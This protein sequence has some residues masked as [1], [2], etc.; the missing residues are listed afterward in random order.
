MICVLIIFARLQAVTD[1]HS[2]PQPYARG[3]FL[4]AG[5]AVYLQAFAVVIF[6]KSGSGACY[7]IG[8]VIDWL[9]TTMLYLC[10]GIIIVSI[11]TLKSCEYSQGN[12]QFEYWCA[13]EKKD[14]TK[15]LA[16]IPDAT[17]QQQA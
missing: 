2:Q 3:A 16:S 14:L 10:I 6:P 13:M 9:A 7:W 1:L 15:A 5:I 4:A 11:C 17:T 8:K 12:K